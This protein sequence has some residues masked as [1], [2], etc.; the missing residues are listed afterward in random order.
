MSG[1]KQKTMHAVEPSGLP[2]GRVAKQCHCGQWYSLPACHAAR[3]HSCTAECAKKRRAALAESR[4]RACEEC[5]AMFLPRPRQLALGQGRYCSQKCNRRFI[6]SSHTPEAREKQRLARLQS[7][8]EWAHKL[9]GENSARWSGGRKATYERRKAKGC[10][11]DQN[12]K[13]RD[14]RRKS[15]PKG[16]IPWLEAKQ[17][18]RCAN[19]ME[20][21]VAGYH[22]DHI[23]PISKGGAHEMGN[24]QLLCP[25]CNRKKRDMLPH[26][27]ASLNGRL[28]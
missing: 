10:I 5:G 7:A 20:S 13:R 8:P 23:T 14:Y 9:R 2:A 15:L 18:M 22:L 28:V 27:W 4:K 11:R 17:K 3:H 16:A 1:N 21:L 12:N 19:C 26:E 25:P 24:V 6:E